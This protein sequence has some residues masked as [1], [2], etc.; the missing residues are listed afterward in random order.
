MK[1]RE[2]G[3]EKK[4]SLKKKATKG[5]NKAGK[6]SEPLRVLILEDSAA[7]AELMERQ[8]RREK[9][10]YRFLRAETRAGFLK[11]LKKFKP[12]LILADYTLPGF[13][14]V[15][16]LALARKQ[17]PLLPFIIVTGSIG[18]E[19]AVACLRAGADD[20]L[21]KDRLGRLGEAMRQALER[22]RQRGE[23]AAMQE[24]LVASEE[25]LR[26]FINSS[27][28]M[29]FL[30]DA[31]FRLLVANQALCR[32]FGRTQE[33]ILGRTDH[34]LMEPKAAARCRRSDRLALKEGGIVVQEETVGGRVFETRKFPVQLADGSRGVGAYI[35]DITENRKLEAAIR[36]RADEWI[37]TF[38]SIRDPIAL[39]DAKGTVHRCNRAFA[40]LSG[41]PFKQIIGRPCHLFAAAAGASCQ[42]LRRALK[43]HRPLRAE[44]ELAGRWFELAIDPLSGAANK[45]QGVVLAMKDVSERRR[46]EDERCRLSLAVEQSPT[47]VIITDPEGRIEF[48]NSKFSELTGYAPAEVLGKNPRL[49]KSGDTPAGEYRRLWRTIRRGGTWRGEFHN[50][51]K[52]GSL[53]W[54]RVAISPVLDGRG[55]INHYVAVKE[56]VTQQKRTNDS[57]RESEN[58]FAAFFRSNPGPIAI[59]R[60]DD[61]RILDVNEAWQNVTGYSRDEAI[62]RTPTELALWPEPAARQRIVD[63]VRAGASV[64]NLEINIQR[65][66]GE[67]RRIL[68]SAD[69][70][71]VGGSACMITMALDISQR[72][73]AEDSLR[74]MNEIFRQFLRYNPLYVF[75]KDENI[76]SVFLSDNYERM[77]GRP[78]TEIIGKTMDELFPS[79]LSRQMIEDDKGILRDG[80]V[81]EFQEELHGRIYSTIKFPIIIDG[82]AKYL[83][84]YTMDITERTRAEDLLRERDQLLQN[85]SAQIP[86][87]IYTFLRRPDG[88]YA[89]PYCSNII[90]EIFGIAPQDVCEDATPI[91]AAIYPEDLPGTV[92]SI[93]KSARD[94]S[95]WQHEFRVQAPGQPPS[96]IWARSQPF[97]LADGSILW[98]GFIADITERKQAEERLAASLKEKEILLKEI[99]HRVKNN[100]QVISGLLTL[101]A[102]QTDDPRL[103]RLVQESQSRIW[104]MALIHQTLYQSGDLAAIEMAEYVRTLAGNLI[105]SQARVAMPPSCRCDVEPLRLPIDQAIPLALIINELLTN[106][107]KHAFPD[108][109]PG[110]IRIRL[111]SLLPPDAGQ[112]ELIV[113]DDGVGLPTGFDPGEQKHLGLLLI[114]MLARQIRGTLACEQ[115]NG[116]RFRIRF[117]LQERNGEH[118]G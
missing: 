95:L 85:L 110:E 54:E 67:T 70:I 103:A 94:M 84:G 87:M 106:A 58:R 24:T 107:L 92:S 32:F 16:A 19:K 112:C 12:A 3:K 50:R 43:S 76:R 88:S 57:L 47:A 78:L 7:D 91:F 9:T 96:W 64:H 18:E 100:L 79:A 93:E 115:D 89:L 37:A 71:V 35:R 74:E 40:L 81:R 4:K 62:G 30:K 59:T 55:R 108:G 2:A 104:T 65:K 82:K 111:R 31:R 23:S 34:Q 98:Y 45:F 53:Y 66:D 17:D 38:D 83:A 90:R 44:V 116:A 56:D 25:L 114:A 48:V 49:L 15:R 27:T 1:K 60:L 46:T 10:A 33:E 109:R 69:R 13:D 5:Q 29:A 105:S 8:L 63:A 101:Q 113:A 86:G 11:G 68:M 97:H 28:D 39:F 75:I 61:H 42:F 51:R 52:D 73:R 14:A 36:Q 6:A 21:L 26:A 20:Y 80:A 117:P 77:L 102:G 72:K 99:H 41:K 22:S 118:H